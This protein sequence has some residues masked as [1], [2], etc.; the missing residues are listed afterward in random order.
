MQ[1]IYAAIGDLGRLWIR[2]EMNRHRASIARRQPLI[3][4]LFAELRSSILSSGPMPHSNLEAVYIHDQRERTRRI[5]VYPPTVA[6]QIIQTSDAFTGCVGL[7]VRIE[8]TLAALCRKTAYGRPRS[9]SSS[10]LCRHSEIFKGREPD[11]I[12]R[13]AKCTRQATNDKTSGNGHGRHVH[14]IS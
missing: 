6:A 8:S 12:E 13:N 1:Q 4:S 3:A 14:R 7:S 2:K 11:T 5:W 10:L 9:Y